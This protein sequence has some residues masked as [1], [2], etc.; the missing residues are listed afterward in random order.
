MNSPVNQSNPL[1]KFMRQPKIYVS[2]PSQ[3]KFW[4]PGSLNMPENGQLPIFSMTAKDELMFKTPDALLNGQ[5]VVDVIQSC[6]PNIKN[7]WACPSTDLD[8]I[9]VAIRIAT[10]GEKMTMSFKIPV[11]NE[12]SDYELDLHAYID[13][14]SNVQWREQVVIDNDMTVFVKPLTY[15]HMT[16]ISQRSFE[17][18]KILQ[19]ADDQTLSDQEKSAMITASFKTLTDLTTDMIVSSIWKIKVGDQ[20]VTEVR[21]I[22]EFVENT[23][24]SV[25]DTIQKHISELKN[26]NDLEPA[27]LN[28]TPEQ[29]ERG[30]PSTVEVP[31]ILDQSTFFA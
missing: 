8:L 27:I 20:D 25:I 6:V 14:F 26:Q 13:H 23:D 9:L 1:V 24:K 30:A 4:A 2:L 5:A 3:G 29:Q 22:K 16:N 15:K 12:E 10:Y 17:T 21:F 31:I 18:N 19:I 28:T 7:A 11:I